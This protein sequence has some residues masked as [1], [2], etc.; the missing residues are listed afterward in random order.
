MRIKKNFLYYT[1]VE[2]SKCH[3]FILPSHAE[4]ESFFKT[5]SP[6]EKEF[7]KQLEYVVKFG[8]GKDV[9]TL[10]DLHAE[11]QRMLQEKKGEENKTDEMI[12]QQLK[13][14]FKAFDNHKTMCRNHLQLYI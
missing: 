1:D 11:L 6:L 5:I 14:L 2:G 13:T 10:L 4:L 3:E 9:V 12:L 8:E 7:S